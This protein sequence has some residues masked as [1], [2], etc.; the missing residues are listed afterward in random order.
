MTSRAPHGTSL[1]RAGDPGRLLEGLGALAQL[2][3]RRNGIAEVDGSIP[4]CSTTP[5]PPQWCG[6]VSGFLYFR[7]MRSEGRVMFAQEVVG[8]DTH[9]R[10]ATI[11][12]PLA[13]Q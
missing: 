11:R 9:E 2:G 10:I 8:A 5:L 4:S 3:E 1:R 12:I 13:L 6:Q 7:K